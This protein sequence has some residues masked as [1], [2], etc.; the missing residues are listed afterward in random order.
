MTSRLRAAFGKV[1]ITPEEHAPLQGYD[2]TANIA[3]PARDVLD[4]IYARI[5]MLDD[6]LSR[7]IVIGT[8]C[9][10]ASEVPFL[11]MN[12]RDAGRFNYFPA[13]F[14]EGTRAA[15][16]EA[17]GAD[18]SSV[19]VIATHTHSAPAYFSRKYTSR[20]TAKI[21]EMMQELRPVRVKVATGEC[22]VSVNR[23]PLLQHNDS[24]PIDRS[25][26]VL[27]FETEEGEPLGALV[28]G[29]VHPTLL[30][31]TFGRVS[32]EFVGLAMNEM[33]ERY[34]GGFVSLFAQ[35]FC[36]DV[37]PVDHYR[38][39]KEDTYPL[40]RAMGHRLFGDI[41]RTVAG[42]SAIGGLPLRSA[43]KTIRLPTREGYYMPS[44]SMT[45]HGLRIGQA[46]LISVSGEIF[47][48][49]VGPIARESP[50]PYTLLSGLA[51]GYS[52]YLPTRAAFHDGLVGYEVNTTPYSDRACEMF[53]DQAAELLRHLHEY[54]PAAAAK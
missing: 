16:G 15:W 23:R 52:G 7:Q 42:L 44:C 28:N 38:T 8:D 27:M 22:T 18:E 9:C 34:G 21:K 20:I 25:L 4:D 26:H 30:M 54:R 19:T 17:A 39:E 41:A 46:A 11:A 3:D 37:G 12:P 5:V 1:K 36:G 53:T 14:A 43:E 6:G 32:G 49:F 33:E 35:G 24:L 45:L 47:N 50:F 13:A 10:V 48:G 31:N 40:V 2:T 29:A 51:N